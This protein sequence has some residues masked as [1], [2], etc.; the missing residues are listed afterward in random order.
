MIG[1]WFQFSP[2]LLDDDADI[3]NLSGA[4]PLPHRLR[5]I[6]WSKWTISVSYQMTQYQSLF[7]SK[8][9]YPS[10]WTFDLVRLKIDRAVLQHNKLRFCP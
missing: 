10:V 8:M 2:E 9:R 5:E 4:V 1:I 6:L 3:L 7:R